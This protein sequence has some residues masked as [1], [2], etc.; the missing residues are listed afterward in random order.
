ML[1]QFSALPSY[2][3]KEKSAV[4]I[5]KASEAFWFQKRSRRTDTAPALGNSNTLSPI[6]SKGAE[7]VLEG[8]TRVVPPLLL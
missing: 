5:K 7:V 8:N 6:P 4:F 1:I 2:Y 3:F